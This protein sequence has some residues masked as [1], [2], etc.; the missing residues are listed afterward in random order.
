M[1]MELYNLLGQ[2]IFLGWWYVPIYLLGLA[3]T[4]LPVRHPLRATLIS[5]Y[6]YIYVYVALMALLRLLIGVF[7]LRGEVSLGDALSGLGFWVA[8]CIPV[9]LL[10]IF[11]DEHLGIG[12]LSQRVNGKIVPGKIRRPDIYGRHRRAANG[13]RDADQEDHYSSYRSS[14]FSGDTR[15]GSDPGGSFSDHTL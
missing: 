3:S 9:A 14:A 11:M 7:V 12:S 2:A 15:N 13:S 10:E 4:L 6:I 1:M 8:L 5:P